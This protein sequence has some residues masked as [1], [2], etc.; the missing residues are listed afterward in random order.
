MGNNSR[1]KKGKSKQPLVFAKNK[2]QA[3]LAIA[4]FVAFLANS[5]FLAVKHFQG[6]S[7]TAQTAQQGTLS[8]NAGDP[9][10]QQDLENLAATNPDSAAVNP[11]DQ[12]IQQD[13]NNIYSQTVGIQQNSSNQN[14]KASQPSEEDVDIL[15][16]KSVR[17]NSGKVVMISVTNTG[18]QDPFMPPDDGLLLGSYASLLP[19]PQTLPQNTDASKIMS[20]TI[21]GILYDKYSPSA[22]INIEGTDYLVKRGDVINKYKI[23]SIGKTQVAVQLGRNIYKAGVGELLSSVDFNN[24]IANLDKKFGGNDVSINVKR[25]GY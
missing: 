23:L 19:P 16:K 20:T 3:I 5:V 8:A 22:I 15:N 21:S 2:K 9:S 13:A 12:N 1:N 24:N 11:Q 17:K 4:V 25:K 6:K 14:L 7:L 18:R 10:S